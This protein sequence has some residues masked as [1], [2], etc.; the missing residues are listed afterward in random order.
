MDSSLHQG[1]LANEI[2]HH[3]GN[4][5][6]L[7]GFLKKF[8]IHKDALDVQLGTVIMQGGKTL[9]FYSKNVSKAQLND[10]IT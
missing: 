2:T 4:H 5:H 9:D 6:S 3:Q 10:K 8:T 1:V 7:S